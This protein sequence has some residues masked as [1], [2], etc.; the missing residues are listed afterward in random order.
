MTTN[1]I[2]RN[3]FNDDLS[4]AKTDTEAILYKKA[5]EKIENLST[6]L[7][8]SLVHDTGEEQNTTERE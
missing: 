1:K 8:N 6:K 5:T 4:K 7:S 3:V 2:I